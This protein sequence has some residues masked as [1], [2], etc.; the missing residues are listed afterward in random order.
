MKTCTKCG[1]EKPRT[2]FYDHPKNK[3]GKQSRCKICTVLA[4]RESQYRIRYN[5]SLQDKEDMIKAQGNQCAICGY[6]FQK[7]KEKHVHVDHCHD[8]LKVRGIL[9]SYCNTGIGLLKNSPEIM[10]NAIKY[11]QN[12]L[13]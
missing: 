5:M 8:T 1:V 12:S 4:G 11:I 3:T 13:K 10:Q 7:G 2:E 9:C 6:Y